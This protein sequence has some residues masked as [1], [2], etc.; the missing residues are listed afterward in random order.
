MD[1]P[2]V[3]PTAACFPLLLEVGLRVTVPCLG[4]YS[5]VLLLLLPINARGLFLRF[6][7]GAQSPYFHIPQQQPLEQS[8][9]P[10]A[11][12]TSSALWVRTFSFDFS[13]AVLLLL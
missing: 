12:I 10:A 13:F 9:S 7:R 11:R 6:L 5:H 4:T 2:S 3:E 8:P 1:S